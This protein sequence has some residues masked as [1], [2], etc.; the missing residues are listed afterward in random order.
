MAALVGAIPIYFYAMAQTAGLAGFPIQFTVDIG[1]TFQNGNHLS[2]YAGLM[3]IVT[4]VAFQVFAFGLVYRVLLAI[5]AIFSLYV[6]W[7][8]QG[9]S[10]FFALVLCTLYQVARMTS[11]LEKKTRIFFLA[12]GAVIIVGLF[13]ALFVFQSTFPALIAK[14]GIPSL[15]YYFE[16][17][18]TVSNDSPLG[19]FLIGGRE[20]NII[21][22]LEYLRSAWL[23]GIGIGNFFS[24]AGLGF[25]LHN[26]FLEIWVELGI[27]GLAALI[28][29]ITLFLQSCARLE[30][31]R[32]A[33]GAHCGI[34]Y[35]ILVC[36]FDPLLSYRSLLT[37]V[38]ILASCVTSQLPQMNYSKH[39]SRL[40]L[41]TVGVALF[42]GIATINFPHQIF[43]S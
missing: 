16:G 40:L 20:R 10:S 39:P 38:A 19:I 7:L 26:S 18:A 1:G 25:A 8:G 6:L 22:G 4:F 37:L 2:F 12:I 13:T 24:T 43:I 33:L 29:G 23:W 31:R 5:F 34:L 9:R 17:L 14:L 36:F 30:N 42:T 27:F 41:A 32:I 15:T 28:L 3:L 35:I 11:R 21:L